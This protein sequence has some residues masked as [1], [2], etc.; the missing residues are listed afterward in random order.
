MKSN[1]FDCNAHQYRYSALL[2]LLVFLFSITT[3]CAQKEIQLYTGAIPN[4]KPTVDSFRMKG[5]VAS[6]VSRPTLTIFLPDAAKANGA[7]VIVC[8]GGGYGALMMQTEG[9]NIAKY[10]QD[11]GV[12][13]F[14]LKYRLPSELTMQDKSI[15]PLQ[16]AQQAIRLVRMNAVEW[17][18]DINRVG[19]M[20][21]SAGGHLASTLSTHYAKS[22]IDNPEKSNLRPDFSLLVYPVISM[23]EKLGHSGSRVSLLG[24]NASVDAIKLFS[25]DEQVTSN[26]PPAFLIHSADDSVVDVDNSINYFQAMRRNKVPVELHVY[27]KGNHGFVLH[28]PIEEWMGLCLKWMERGGWLKGKD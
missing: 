23:G 18:V 5:G 28:M 12:A 22:L 14:V 4:S 7:A 19:I 1:P 16:D 21:F 15:G 26:T 20:G 17:K 3:G 25:N 24:S 10:Y 6:K 9:Y 27:P 13:A 2:A 8:P 11:H